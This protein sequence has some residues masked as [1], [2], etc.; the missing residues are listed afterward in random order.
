MNDDLHE[1]R[2]GKLEDGHDK[3]A[4][5]VDALESDRDKREGGERVR[6][7]LFGVLAAMLGQLFNAIISKWPWGH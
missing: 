4:D 5:R 6:L 3:L 2:L 7:A 1:H